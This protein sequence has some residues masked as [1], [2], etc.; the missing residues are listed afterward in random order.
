MGW[1]IVKN[2]FAETGVV[3]AA[4]AGDVFTNSDIVADLLVSAFCV[5]AVLAVAVVSFTTLLVPS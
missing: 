4:L 2:D 5:V 3:S 1:K